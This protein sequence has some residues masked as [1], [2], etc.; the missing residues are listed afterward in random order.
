MCTCVISPLPR[1]VPLFA[2]QHGHLPDG[3][4]NSGRHPGG[5]QLCA[6]ARQ[7]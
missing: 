6:A 5:H 2:P 4:R 7:L 1:P 3:G